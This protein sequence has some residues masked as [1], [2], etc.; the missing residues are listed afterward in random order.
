MYCA[1]VNGWVPPAIVTEEEY[2]QYSK[3]RD[4]SDPMT[5]FV[6]FGCSFSGKWFG[7]YARD[8]KGITDSSYARK[9]RNSLMRKVEGF[10]KIN[11]RCSNY[12]S[13]SVPDGAV[14]YCDPPYA[15]TTEYK[16]V[17]EFDSDA[18]WEWTRILSKKATV[19]ISEYSAPDDMNLVFSIDRRLQMQ[20]NDQDNVPRIEHIYSPNSDIADIQLRKTKPV[21]FISRRASI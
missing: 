18:F 10:Q 17:A 3:I 21:G 1:L 20:T 16:G 12:H 11:W 7:G 19:F 9:A 8:V 13:L 6:G 2:Q 15:G 4:L 5:A 14:V